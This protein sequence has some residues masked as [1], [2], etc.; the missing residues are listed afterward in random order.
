MTIALILPQRDPKD[1]ARRIRDLAPDIDV[2]CWP[3]IREPDS[4]R[5]AVAWHQPEGAMSEFPNLEAVS[6]FGA[7]V[8]SLVADPTLPRSVQLG[9][10]VYPGLVAQMSQYVIAAVLAQHRGLWRYAEDQREQ[11]WAPRF[12]G[13]DCAVGILG[14]GELGADAARKMSR[15][16]LD[17]AGWSRTPKSLPGVA[18]LTGDR[19]LR[20]LAARSDV[21][22]CLLPLIPETRGILGMA[23]FRVAKPGCF[24]VNAARGGH[25]VEDDLLAALAEGYLSGACLDVFH[26]E[27]LPPG[28]P[29]WSHPQIRVTPHVASMT[30]LQAAA[31]H[32]VE[33]YRRLEAGG[34]L[35]HPVNK[36]RGY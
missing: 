4:V 20:D 33:D 16:G 12:A 21:L 32:I 8:D 25:L 14:L 27:P 36:E 31:E 11:R 6:S 9:R 34:S 10:I 29:F 24:L 26:E 7:G 22:V 28:H 1:L 13:P 5:L 2:Q 30:D 19:G 35:Q 18:C 3:D 17:V 15:L 23:L